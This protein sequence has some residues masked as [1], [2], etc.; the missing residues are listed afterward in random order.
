M[1][2]TYEPISTQTLSSNQSSITL[3]SIPQTYTDLVIVAEGASTSGGSMCARFNGDAGSNYSTEYLYGDG[4][5]VVNSRVAIGAVGIFGP[6]NAIGT[7]G[8]GV[9][10]ILNYSNSTTFK[11]MLSRQFGSVHIQWASCGLWRST[12]GITTIAFTDESGGS[13]TTG[14]KIS[15]YG[16][17]AA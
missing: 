7:P 4:S 1:P 8:G 17:K 11:T 13:F 14:F 15:L 6:R 12:A 16:I 2:R 9:M 3:T 5:S 10:H